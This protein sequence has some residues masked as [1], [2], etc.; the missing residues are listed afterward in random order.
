MPTLTHAGPRTGLRIDPRGA[1]FSAA[2]TSLLL[3]LVLV[4]PSLP[5]TLLTALQLALFAAGASLGVQR[6]PTAWIFRA[7]VRPHLREPTQLEDAAP[8]RFAQGVGLAF[9]SIALV[10]FVAGWAQ[11]AQL[12]IG[13]ALV[14]ALLN[15]VF[16]FCLGCELYLILHRF[17]GRHQTAIHRTT[18]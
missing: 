11:L 10:A 13:S 12:A 3:A 4:L 18:T 15:A 17:K 16:G 2:V 5:A 7:A 6:T 9:A 14:A 1:R 8:P